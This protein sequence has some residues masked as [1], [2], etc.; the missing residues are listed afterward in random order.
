MSSITP[1]SFEG[2]PEGEIHFS[3]WDHNIGMLVLNSCGALLDG[4]P[5]SPEAHKKT[6]HIGL[7][8]ET[9]IPCPDQPE[10]MLTLDVAIPITQ[11]QFDGFTSLDIAIPTQPQAPEPIKDM[12][13]T[14]FSSNQDEGILGML[15]PS[16]EDD[17]PEPETTPG[18]GYDESIVKENIRSLKQADMI[19]QFA[20]ELAGT[21]QIDRQFEMLGEYLPRSSRHFVDAYTSMR[22]SL[23]NRQ[24]RRFSLFP[25]RGSTDAQEKNGN[26]SDAFYGRYQSPI[27]GN[28]YDGKDEPDIQQDIVK[29][30]YGK[31][32]MQAAVN[33]DVHQVADILRSCAAFM[34][35]QVPDIYE[36]PKPT[37][38]LK[39]PRLTTYRSADFLSGDRQFAPGGM[40]LMHANE[41]QGITNEYAYEA[42]IDVSDK[43][44]DEARPY[45]IH[46][47][48]DA[49]A[50]QGS[51]TEISLAAGY[52]IESELEF[53]QSSL[54]NH[55]R[56][57]DQ[58]I[59]N[60]IIPDSLLA[61]MHQSGMTKDNIAN[62]LSG[63]KWGELR[64]PMSH[65]DLYR[66]M[67]YIDQ[68]GARAA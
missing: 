18:R 55:Y 51:Q 66:A 52:G 46:F 10:N 57:R 48:A 68:I 17:H 28:T 60:G 27:D 65:T 40:H 16:Q 20:N 45:T 25:E 11:A 29:N 50:G 49:D 12:A 56:K 47:Y 39:Q 34:R 62:I 2:F 38:W 35:S 7:Q 15:I 43:K 9:S 67:Q 42:R 4:T 3:T 61:Q 13:N 26:F 30:I 33:Q 21:M 5:L 36:R 19:D 22:V 54:Y 6:H 37:D 1:K 59:E 31:D 24:G 53:A 58:Y 14:H 23:T 64:S 32:L 8:T 44:T 41:V 63:K